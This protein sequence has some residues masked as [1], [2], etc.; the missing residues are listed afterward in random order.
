MVLSWP[1]LPWVSGVWTSTPQIFSQPSDNTQSWS[2]RKIWW[3]LQTASTHTFWCTCSRVK[4][5]RR[6][7]GREPYNL[8][9][10]I[11]RSMQEPSAIRKT[12]NSL[13]GGLKRFKKGSTMKKFWI[14]KYAPRRSRGGAGLLSLTLSMFCSRVAV[15]GQVFSIFSNWKAIP[16]PTPASQEDLSVHV[17]VS[18]IWICPSKCPSYS[19]GALKS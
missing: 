6:T 17:M 3:C 1:L 4:S 12:S 10:R 11:S 5:Q 15:L 2:I 14:A 16:I 19:H 9:K 8:P 18:A 13:T 7:K